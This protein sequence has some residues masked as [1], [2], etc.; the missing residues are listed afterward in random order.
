[1]KRKIHTKTFGYN[2][3]RVE[4]TLFVHSWVR[5][6]ARFLTRVFGQGF[7]DR[8]YR[9]TGLPGRRNTVLQFHRDRENLGKNHVIKN[10]ILLKIPYIKKLAVGFPNYFLFKRW[11]LFLRAPGVHHGKGCIRPSVSS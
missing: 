4:A 8:K 11:S 2:E 7:G 5:F 9:F 3:K 1:M 10:P 6:W